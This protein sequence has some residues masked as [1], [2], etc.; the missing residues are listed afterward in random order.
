MSQ[1]DAELLT[2]S[3]VAQ[4]PEWL[5]VFAS[6]SCQEALGLDEGTVAGRPLLDLVHPGDR[7][8]LRAALQSNAMSQRSELLHVRLLDKTGTPA[9]FEVQVHARGSNAGEVFVFLRQAAGRHATSVREVVLSQRDPLTGA[10][11]RP[12][13]LDHAQHALARL[14]RD[15]VWVGLLFLDLDRL[16]QVNDTLG[17]QAGDEVLRELTRRV[18]ALLRPVDT[19]ARLGGDEFAVLVDDFRQPADAQR[20]AKRIVA[21][22]RATFRVGTTELDC[23][24][25]VGL[26]V[27][28]A[29][30]QTI[31][32]LL[33]Q[34]DV[35]MYEAKSAGRG[36]WRLWGVRDQVRL[37]ARHRLETLLRE[38]LHQR[39]LR[40]EYQPVV[41]LEDGR[42]IG[43]EAL[44]RVIGPGGEILRPAA[45]LEVATSQRLIG[46]LDL[47]V[48]HQAMSDRQR[49]STA[50]PVELNLATVDLED[51]AWADEALAALMRYGEEPGSLHVELREGLLRRLSPDALQRL[52]ALRHG[53]VLVGVDGFGSDVS[54]MTTLWSFPLDYVKLHASVTQQLP[55]VRAARAT[56]RAVCE[57]AHGLDLVVTAA[58]VETAEQGA[59]AGQAGCDYGQGSLWPWPSSVPGQDWTPSREEQPVTN[60]LQSGLIPPARRPRN[61]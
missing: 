38:S 15:P 27:T 7:D 10:V 51:D 11:T 33:R 36:R 58:G 37:D 50:M 3:V 49:Q 13:L 34:A 61:P 41:R 59:L 12:V 16:K 5:C 28:S 23:S 19:F 9:W 18:R 53:G 1:P 30:G 29:A 47:E 40:I 46:P 45:F 26:T 21:A 31:E 17:H 55:S 39:S 54:A 14:D 4:G 42:H 60:G 35:A 52:A 57:L 20:L 6:P 32:T 48:L 24:V 22:S 8:R 56:A 2:F 43:S 25:S 44:L